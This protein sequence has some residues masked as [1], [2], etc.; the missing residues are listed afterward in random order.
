MISHR[1]TTSGFTLIELLVVIAIIAVLVSLLLPAVQSARE[2]ARRAQCTNNLKQ[3][4][5]ALHNYEEALG[6][7]PFGKGGD[8][9][10]VLP[11]A[12]VH[13][14]WSAHSQILGFLEQKPLYDAINFSLPP[15]TP[16]AG[17][18][19]MG[20]GMMA[21]YQD[22]NRENSTVCRIVISAFLCPSD[23]A[24]APSDWPGGNNYMNNDGNWLSDA[25]EKY[26]PMIG[27]SGLPRGPFY[28]RSS[29]RLAG[30][31][32]GLSNTAFASEKKRG[33]GTY[34]A[35]RD[36]FQMG[37][38]MSIDDTFQQC[39]AL[40]PSSGMAT[41][42]DSWM[43]TAWCVGDI[44]STNYNHVAGPNSTTCTTM[45][46]MM[47]GGGPTSMVNVAVQMP[48]SSEHPGGVNLLMGDG[49]VR[50]I[51]AQPLSVS[52]VLWARATAARSSAR[53]TIDARSRRIEQSV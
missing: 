41:V 9:M 50:F 42:I 46:G 30:V 16:N 26:P 22:P 39:T 51:R 29:I 48:P 21:A 2:S 35:S 32:G 25:C 19:G 53:R 52:G 40:N 13:A 14:R 17:S 34:D 38:T 27:A 15:E 31:T 36:M 45:S 12:P 33:M 18:M 4:G 37:S 7:L 49:S 8:Y 24:T 10:S 47:M 5:L 23:A 1:R 3:F 6:C 44:S 43:G 28:N 20:M 11:A